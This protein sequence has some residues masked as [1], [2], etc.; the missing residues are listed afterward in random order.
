MSIQTFNLSGVG[1]NLSA[2]GDIVAYAA[3]GTESTLEAQVDLQSNERLLSP[4]IRIEFKGVVETY[5]DN[6]SRLASHPS[7][8]NYPITHAV[9][10]FHHLAAV[11]FDEAVLDPSPGGSSTLI[12][13]SFDLPTADLPPSFYSVSGAIYYFIKCTLTFSTGFSFINKSRELVVPVR[14]HMPDSAKLQMTRHLRQLTHIGQETTDRIYYSLTIPTLVVYVG[15]ALNV[16]L[17]IHSTPTGTRLREVHLTLTPIVAYYNNAGFAHR[18]TF[19]SPI[20]KKVERFDDSSTSFGT[21]M[22]FSLN[23]DSDTALLTFESPLIISK[24]YLRLTMILDNAQEPNI[25]KEIPITVLPR[26]YSSSLPVP[27][28][29]VS[30]PTPLPLTPS[31]PHGNMDFTDADEILTI[32]S[33]PEYTPLSYEPTSPSD[34]TLNLPEAITTK[35]KS[36]SPTSWNVDQVAEWVLTMGGSDELAKTFVDQAID[37]SVLVTLTGNDLSNELGVKQLGPR[38]KMELAI[39]QMR[40]SSEE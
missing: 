35:L 1:S 21:T 2:E 32:H 3:W 19:P 13:F 10:T 8:K 36:N 25:V 12:P 5:W 40:A 23:V 31:I 11:I 7:S 30:P 24:T 6:R 38:K 9:R 37:G 28:I 39:Q 27:D 17:Q 4:K 16:N 20:S 18:S 33:P 26:L 15:D 29:V 34:E 22:R 14:I